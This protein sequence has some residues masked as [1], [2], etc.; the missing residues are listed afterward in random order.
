MNDQTTSSN[1]TADIT[2]QSIHNKFQRTLRFLSVSSI[3]DM[4]PQELIDRKS[5]NIPPHLKIADLQFHWNLIAT[6]PSL[7]L[8]CIGQIKLTKKY[9]DFQMHLT[10]DTGLVFMFVQ[11][12]MP[13]RL[14][15][16]SF[17]LNLV[18]PL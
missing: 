10:M 16:I 3:T 11:Q 5:L 9:T 17:V 2:F 13:T 4:V 6:G 14:R 12:T 1:Y 7:S 8:M 15:Y 18:W